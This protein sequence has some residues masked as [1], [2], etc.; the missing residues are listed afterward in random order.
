MSV[1]AS[2]RLAGRAGEAAGSKVMLTLVS[3]SAEAAGAAATSWSMISIACRGA[4]GSI[5][6][7]TWLVSVV[8]GSRAV[9][10]VM[11]TQ[12]SEGR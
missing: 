7:A 6:A 10:T 2:A 4:A 8:P 5:A 9:S 11:V 1:T 12:R 3:R